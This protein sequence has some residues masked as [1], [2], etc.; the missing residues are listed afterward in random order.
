MNKIVQYFVNLGIALIHIPMAVV[1]KYRYNQKDGYLQ[2]L[3]VV[4]LDLLGNTILGG[5]PNET[6][7]SR[8]GKAQ[9]YEQSLN[10]PRY[11]LGCRLCA[12]LAVFQQD[13][14]QKAL[15]RHTGD[16]AVIPDETP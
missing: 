3:A 10:P 2:N 4:A 15:N 11:G 6:I 16:Q 9:A 14:C 7:S 5:D 13:H 8:S 1:F 12:F